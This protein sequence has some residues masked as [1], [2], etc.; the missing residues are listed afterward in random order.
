LKKFNL[1]IANYIIGFE[2]ADPELELVPSMRFQRNICTNCISDILIT[3]HPGPFVLPRDAERVFH[4][5]FVKEVNGIVVEKRDNFWS[6]YKHLPDL[7]IKTDFP[8]SSGGK[9]GILKF[10]LTTRK[11]DLYI[12][13]GGNETDPMEYPLDGL[14]LYYLTVIYGDIMIHASGIDH[15]GHGYLFSGV[16]GKGKSTIAGL[17]DTAGAKVIHDDR[18]IIRNISGV[19]RIFN[20]PVYNDDCPSSSN[21]N[22]IY[23]IEH[24]LENEIVP[25]RGAAAVSLL[26]ANCIQHSWNK[27]IIAGMMGSLSLLCSSIPVVKLSFRPDRSVIDFLLEYE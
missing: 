20:T 23:L 21:L 9:E 7:Y 12:S 1:N 18:L 8:L 19:F 11:W 16:S 6:V 14:I 27:S 2:S 22:R 13:G 5:P 10:S 3:V 24:G 17:W 15:A 25:V 26:M 4:A